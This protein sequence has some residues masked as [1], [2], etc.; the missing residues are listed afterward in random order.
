M[1]GQL[2]HL[3]NRPRSKNEDAPAATT[4]TTS[5]TDD[6]ATPPLEGLNAAQQ[7]VITMQR[8]RG[9]QA[10]CRTLAK[11]MNRAQRTIGDGHDLSSPRFAADTVLQAVFDDERELKKGDSGSPVRTVQKAL[12]DSGHNLPAFGADGDFGDETESSVKNFQASAGLPQSKQD[13]VIRSDTIERLDHIFPPSARPAGTPPPEATD[14]QI[15]GKSPDAASFPNK[16]FFD[17]NDST[18]DAEEQAKIPALATPPGQVLSL[19]GFASEEGSGNTALVNARIAAV[20]SALR[21]AGHNGTRTPIP[22]PRAGQGNLDYRSMR[23]VEVVTAGATPATRDCDAPGA[24]DLPC[25][26]AFDTGKPEAE[27]LID[28]A[29]AALTASPLTADTIA[30]LKAVGL[31]PANAPQLATNLG[32]IRG[33]LQ[34]M[35]AGHQCHNADCDGSCAGGAT[36]YNN[37]DGT[38]AMM[39]LCPIFVN[40]PSATERGDTLIHEGSHGTTGLITEDLAYR[41]QRL[42]SFLRPNEALANADSYSLFVRIIDDPSSVTV[43]PSNPDTLNGITDPTEQEDLHRAM[44]FVE[45]C[46]EL[47]SSQIASLYDEVVA[48]Q[49][50]SAW[51]NTFYEHMMSL[52]A[53]RFG[54]TAPRAVPN[55]R[56]RN[57]IAALA[58][59]FNQM[60]IASS[61]RTQLTFT[62]DAAIDSWAAGPGAD[63]TLSPAFFALPDIPSKADFLMTL[64]IEATPD[65]SS[66]FVPRYLEVSKLIRQQMGGVEP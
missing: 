62:K 45:K 15:R 29:V 50:N 51:K 57:A 63:V 52:I 25:G 40:E 19:N 28:K 65:I 34:N 30:A 9:N 41:F 4:K 27:R 24:K 23:A 11:P 22:K 2:I 39:T 44:A 60:F 49:K 42:I 53:P 55:N 18:L 21:D 33:Q 12:V 56:D 8:T 13:G 14:F 1:K 32:S 16:L 10:V 17:F 26:T 6:S 54:L 36:A 7:N 61:D 46:I 48:A 31:A 58:D 20:N 37:G 35:V 43:G 64:L 3:L 66:G 59:R 47:S 5:Q 38:T